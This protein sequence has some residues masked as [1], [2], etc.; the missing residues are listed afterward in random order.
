MWTRHVPSWPLARRLAGRVNRVS[1]TLSDTATITGERAD[2]HQGSTDFRY[3]RRPRTC[4][5]TK[6]SD[7]PAEYSAVSS[8]LS[9][10]LSDR[11]GREPLD[12]GSWPVR[13]DQKRLI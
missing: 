3:T 2:F 8:V 5:L 9:S 11:R 1:M 6:L 13:I 4:F 10:G 7:L 12:A